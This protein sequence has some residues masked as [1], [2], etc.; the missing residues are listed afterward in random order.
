MVDKAAIEKDSV[1]AKKAIE[2]YETVLLPLELDTRSLYYWARLSVVHAAMEAQDHGN[3]CTVRFKTHYL[4]KVIEASSVDIVGDYILM[5]TKLYQ[6]AAPQS[7]EQ[8]L[9]DSKFEQMKQPPPQPPPPPTIAV[10]TWNLNDNID[11]LKRTKTMRERVV[12][13]IREFRGNML[14]AKNDPVNLAGQMFSDT[15]AKFTEKMELLLKKTRKVEP[16]KV[17]IAI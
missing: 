5:V 10:Y 16:V 7:D 12:L 17:E 11:L 1:V 13:A 3:W 2:E 8:D 4:R 9:V 6:D 14:F 15:P